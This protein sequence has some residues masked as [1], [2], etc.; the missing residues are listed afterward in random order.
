MNT[1]LTIYLIVMAVAH[2]AGVVQAGRGGNTLAVI[3]NAALLSVSM[4]L[5]VGGV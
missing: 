5:L 3:I 1:L 4:V 2:A